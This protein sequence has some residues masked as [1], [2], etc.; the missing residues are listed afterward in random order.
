[1]ALDLKP[2]SARNMRQDPRGAHAFVH[3]DHDSTF[4]TPYFWS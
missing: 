4:F 3:A 2:S 1:M